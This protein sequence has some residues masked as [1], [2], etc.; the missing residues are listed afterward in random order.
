MLYFIPEEWHSAWYP[1]CICSFSCLHCLFLISQDMPFQWKS[2]AYTKK[3]CISFAVEFFHCTLWQQT[4][5]IFATFASNYLCS[6]VPLIKAQCSSA[7]VLKMLTI[8]KFQDHVILHSPDHKATKVGRN[9]RG[10]NRD[11][12]QLFGQAQYSAVGWNAELSC[13]YHTWWPPQLHFLGNACSS[14]GVPSMNFPIQKM[15]I[16]QILSGHC[17]SLRV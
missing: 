17:T 11:T 6:K 9:S 15:F 1:H 2:L 16:S 12:W 5:H 4:S 8:R 3:N 13:D 14:A 7:Q 10:A